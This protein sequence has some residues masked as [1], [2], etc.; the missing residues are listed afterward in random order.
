MLITLNSLGLSI[1]RSIIDMLGG[2]I[3]IRS[4]VGRGTEVKMT[5]PM[6]RIRSSEPNTPTST[7]SSIATPDRTPDNSIALLQGQRPGSSVLLYGFVPDGRSKLLVS[8]QGK[9]LQHYVSDW[10]GFDIVSTTDSR[11][12]DIAIVDERNV[13]A[14][15]AEPISI[16][17]VIILCGNTPLYGDNEPFFSGIGVVEYMSKPFGPYKLAKVMHMCFDKVEKLQSDLETSKAR[18]ETPSVIP[19][20]LIP[21]EE[22]KIL[23]FEG[24]DDE[25]PIIAQSNGIITASNPPIA[26]LA[27]ES[28]AAGGKIF[29]AK[30]ATPEFP[31]PLPERA[32]IPLEE[33]TERD[34]SKGDFKKSEINVVLASNLPMNSTIERTAIAGHSET[35]STR[36]RSEAM[37]ISCPP[38]NLSREKAVPK[39]L[40]VDDNKINLRLLQTFISKRKYQT[41]DFAENGYL[42][43]QAAEAQKDGYDIIFMGKFFHP[44][45]LANYSI[46]STSFLTRSSRHL[47]ADHERFRSHARDSQDRGIAARKR[48]PGRPGFAGL[49]H[50]FDGS[51]VEPGSERGVCERR[52]YFHDE[53]GV[54]Q[55][56]WEV[57]G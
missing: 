19:E 1:V 24:N 43:V 7:P 21:V 38:F 49:N 18:L 20:T 54:V 9:V 57:V 13:A 30:T 52:G 27:I 44:I 33:L 48:S 34:A 16:T 29:K 39:V 51:G 31:F 22:F 47:H 28:L 56:D 12:V 35:V 55:G 37:N 10:Y 17:S 36:D 4:Q 15:H 50:C 11:S 14:L 8:D 25:P 45:R 46:R 41:V 26:Q 32:E 6:G 23:S 42:A 53:A 40:L 5:I 3:D 2:S